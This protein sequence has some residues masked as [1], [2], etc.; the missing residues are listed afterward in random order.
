MLTKK[1]AVLNA[2][3]ELFAEQGFENTS[4]AKICEEAGVSKGLVYHH[5]KT[6]DDILKQIFSD[7]TSRM[8]AISNSAEASSDS[9]QQIIELIENI[10]SQLKADKLYFQLNLNI[11]L[12]PSTRL[13]LKDLIKIRTTHIL[14]VTKQ[15]FKD[16]DSSQNEIMS[17]MFIAEIDGI[18]LNYLTVFDD[19]P[20]EDIKNHLISKYNN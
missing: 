13:I 3:T 9:G 8:I 10:F 1:Y 6:K 20:L 16:I 18:A 19:Y 7:A 5:F 15:I 2:A 11:M 4:V 17:Y 14:E 12:Q